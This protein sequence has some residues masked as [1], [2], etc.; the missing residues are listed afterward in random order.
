MSAWAT[1]PNRWK[2]PVM[3]RLHWVWEFRIGLRFTY[4]WSRIMFTP[5]D[6]NGTFQSLDHHPLSNVSSKAIYDY[7]EMGD[8]LL[9]SY[10]A[11]W[12]TAMFAFILLA[13]SIYRYRLS[14]FQPWSCHNQVYLSAFY[15]RIILKKLYRVSWV[16]MHPALLD[17]AGCAFTGSYTWNRL[18]LLYMCGQ[19]FLIS[20]PWNNYN[21]IFKLK[22]QFAPTA[23]INGLF[24]YFV[25][26]VLLYSLSSIYKLGF[27]ATRHH[28]TVIWSGNLLTTYYF[29]PVRIFEG[30]ILSMLLYGVFMPNYV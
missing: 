28:V 10:I 16:C 23:H 21:H 4:I 7:E 14:L 18:Q 22:A 20:V 2:S 12:W 5:K 19:T 24:T 9:I 29:E 15:V 1:G 30:F 26:K 17:T 3:Y 27:C 6:M 13:R 8:T 11:F 25:S